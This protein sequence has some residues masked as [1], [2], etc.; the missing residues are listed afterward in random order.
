MSAVFLCLLPASMNA[1]QNIE[2][3]NRFRYRLGSGLFK[4]LLLFFDFSGTSGLKG[5][6]GL[7]LANFNESSYIMDLQKFP[8]LSYMSV[9]KMVAQINPKQNRAFSD[10]G[11]FAHFST[12]FYLASSGK[13]NS[14]VIFV[15]SVKGESLSNQR[16]NVLFIHLYFF[17]TFLRASKKIKNYRKR[18]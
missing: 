1:H 2:T 18:E 5:F 4:F 15:L 12:Y 9:K 14:D 10:S 8:L 3:Q 7:F 11:F 13:E 17:L 16:Q 6:F